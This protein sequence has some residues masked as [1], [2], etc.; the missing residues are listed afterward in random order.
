MAAA[1]C[2]A[3]S[4]LSGKAGERNVYELC[5]R[6][7]GRLQRVSPVDQ[8]MPIGA[9]L[10]RVSS[11]VGCAWALTAARDGRRGSG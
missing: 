7:M 9:A 11:D 8:R 5:T 2:T 4:W 1:T 10:T 6:L 3:G